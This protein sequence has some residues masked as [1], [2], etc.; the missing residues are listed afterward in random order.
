[1]SLRSK[2]TQQ[3]LFRAA[4]AIP[5]ILAFLL[6]DG[7]LSSNNK[8]SLDIT[9]NYSTNIC[10]KKS[11]V[12]WMEELSTT[13][14]APIREP[15]TQFVYESISQCPFSIPSVCKFCLPL[16]VMFSESCQVVLTINYW[17]G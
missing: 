13:V 15:D 12:P 11:I 9:K 1:M 16:Q 8:I 10:I 5:L 7:C 4:I 17:G 6:P 2:N 3:C 14:G